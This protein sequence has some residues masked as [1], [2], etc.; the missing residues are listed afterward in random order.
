MYLG[1]TP[2]FTIEIT[3][4]IDLS[5]IKNIYITIEQKKTGVEITKSG[6]DIARQDNKFIAS[7]TQEDTL[8]FQKGRAQIQLKAVIDNSPEEDI[9][10]ATPIFEIEVKDALYLE[11][12]T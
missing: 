9:V 7:F 11:I 10:L 8:K 2:K 6:S 1:T 12:A 5:R 4:T 3:D